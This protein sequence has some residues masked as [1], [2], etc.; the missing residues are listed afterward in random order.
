MRIRKKC[1]N[2]VLKT[3]EF[4]KLPT[5]IILNSKKDD[6]GTQIGAIASNVSA[7]P[8]PMHSDILVFKFHLLNA[9]VQRMGLWPLS[10]E[11][12]CCKHT[13]V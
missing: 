3:S 1:S 8:H 5:D 7:Y 6:Q 10:P 12:Q 2:E 11:I 9:K 13:L 4:T